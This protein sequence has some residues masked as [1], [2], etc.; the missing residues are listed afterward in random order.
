[1][2]LAKVINCARIL[3]P[4]WCLLWS[5]G[6][7]KNSEKCLTIC[8]LRVL[9]CWKRGCILAFIFVARG[10]QNRGKMPAKIDHNGIQW[11]ENGLQEGVRKRYEKKVRKRSRRPVRAGTFRS[12][13]VPL[14]NIPEWE[15]R[16]TLTALETLHW[17]PRARWRIYIYIYIYIYTVCIYAY[18][19][20]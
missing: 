10:I 8:N 16:D 7:H 12:P 5:L 11:L 15:V 4:F 20:M 1:M 9:A 18:T 6:D 13:V 19:H 2:H 17:C 3:S 14:K